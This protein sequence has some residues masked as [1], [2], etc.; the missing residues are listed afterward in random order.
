[1]N[2]TLYTT[3]DESGTKAAY[4]Y[5][6]IAENGNGIV[7][8]IPTE[9]KKEHKPVTGLRRVELIAHVHI[10]DLKVYEQ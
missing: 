10:N 4:I 2:N 6:I 5:K 7:T 8:I 1:M 3:K 9:T